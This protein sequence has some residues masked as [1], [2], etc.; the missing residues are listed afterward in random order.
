MWLMLM[1]T[2]LNAYSRWSLLSCLAIL[3][4]VEKLCSV[5]N[6]VSIE[7]D[8]VVVIA[9]EH[10]ESLRNM[11]SQMRRVDVICKLVGPFI[12]SLLDGFS[13]KLAIEVNFAVKILSAVVEYFAI[14]KLCPPSLDPS[15]DVLTISIGLR[16]FACLARA[17][18]A[19]SERTFPR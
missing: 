18:T 2:D 6:L 10:E 17:K 19:F 11:N 5:M 7:R 4:C 1:L 13:T 14:H 9:G 12:I 15:A 3:A 16:L 8:W